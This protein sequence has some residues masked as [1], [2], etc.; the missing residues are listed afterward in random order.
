MQAT[1]SCRKRVQLVCVILG[2]MMQ[3]MSFVIDEER[4]R[5]KETTGKLHV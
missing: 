1:G 2:C 3:W 5:E 4:L